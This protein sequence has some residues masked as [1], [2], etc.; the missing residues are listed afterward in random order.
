MQASL[1]GYIEGPR[2]ELDWN[3]VD[4][5]LHRHFNEQERASQVLLYGRRLYQLMA[6]YWPD[7]R[8]DSSLP[9][10]MREYSN[11]WREKQKVVFS[12]SLREVG[13]NSRLV[14]TDAVEEV[15]RLKQ[16]GEGVMSVGGATLAGSLIAAGLVDEFWVYL[17]PVTLGGGK[18]MFG[19]QAAG[20]QLRLMATQQFDSGVMLLRYE[21]G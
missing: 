12:G 20:L 6:G 16:Q 18:P 2:G 4:E 5:R 1:D 14:T 15:A 13:W 11:I 7:A 3:R 17:T 10:Y 19:P 21:R 8:D 9:D